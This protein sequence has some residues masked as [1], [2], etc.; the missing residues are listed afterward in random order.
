[1]WASSLAALRLSTLRCS[2]EQAP[3]GGAVLSVQLTR[4]AAFNAVS[5]ELLSELHRV[6]DLCEHPKSMLDALPADFP[7]VIVLRW[8]IR[9]D[10]ARQRCPCCPH[11]PSCRR[12]GSVPPRSPPFL[13][14]PF[15]DAPPSLLQRR[16]TGLLRRRGHQ[17]ELM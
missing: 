3:S 6:F 17:G 14:L 12:R 1:M 10:R 11:N 16:W 15:I 9:G 7:R 8:P 4:P 5:M 2:L 13:P